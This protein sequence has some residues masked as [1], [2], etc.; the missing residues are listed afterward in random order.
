MVL[1][2]RSELMT[3]TPRDKARPD[4]I[5]HEM[6]E[7]SPEL[8]SVQELLEAWE[9]RSR[10]RLLQRDR[11]LPEQIVPMLPY[12]FLAEPEDEDWRYLLFG[13]ALGK[14][15]GARL[16]N[17]TLRAVYDSQSAEGLACLFEAVA[18]G[19]MPI[20]VRGRFI[21]GGGDAHVEGVLIPIAEP[22]GRILILGGLFF[23]PPRLVPVSMRGH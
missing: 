20:A 17:R 8:S 6:E 7:T 11:I 4:L 18:H 9:E 22:D 21:G 16:A 23:L 19:R 15:I 1:H 12:V 13:A 14:R 5:R 3:P 2:F 10:S